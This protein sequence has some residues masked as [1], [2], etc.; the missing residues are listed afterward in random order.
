MLTDEVQGKQENM[1]HKSF[2]HDACLDKV[3][4]SKTIINQSD[5][6]KS[7]ILK[8]VNQIKSIFPE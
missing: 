5:L 7:G 3:S 2:L 1:D 4:D 8:E 6:G